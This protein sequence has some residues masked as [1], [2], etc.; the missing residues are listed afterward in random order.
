MGPNQKKTENGSHKNCIKTHEAKLQI[1]A[2]N[3]WILDKIKVARK[4]GNVSDINTKASLNSVR[5]TLLYVASSSKG[6]I[7]SP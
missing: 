6:R 1:S 4:E 5:G 2:P 7:P 3:P